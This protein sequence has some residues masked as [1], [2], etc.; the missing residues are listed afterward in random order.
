MN[1]DIIG[2][3]MGAL[4]AQE[5]QR[6]ENLIRSDTDLQ[7]QVDLIRRS[8]RPLESYRHCEPPSDLHN[9]TLAY[10]FDQVDAHKVGST[11]SMAQP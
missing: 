2:F 9:Q 1:E 3:V 10:V 6:I 5:H 11:I 7:S 4:D 8:L